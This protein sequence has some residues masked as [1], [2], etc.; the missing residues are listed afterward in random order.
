MVLYPARFKRAKQEQ[1]NMVFKWRTEIEEAQ[2]QQH[3]LQL[4]KKNLEEHHYATISLV[5]PIRRLL[6]EILGT[7]LLFIIPG[8]FKW[9]DL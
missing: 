3:D 4:E 5:T 8:V 7:V 1:P 2:A 9:E 6:D